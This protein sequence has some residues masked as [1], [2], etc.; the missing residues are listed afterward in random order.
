MFILDS[1]LGAPTQHSKGDN[2]RSLFLR[3]ATVQP[4]WPSWVGYI[5]LSFPL[6]GQCLNQLLTDEHLGKTQDT[7]TPVNRDLHPWLSQA[8][9]VRGLL[10]L[11]KGYLEQAVPAF[12]GTV[13]I[14]SRRQC[15]QMYILRD[16]RSCHYCQF[17]P[18]A[19][20]GPLVSCQSWERVCKTPMPVPCCLH[21]CAGRGPGGQSQCSGHSCFPTI[22]CTQLPN[23]VLSS[24]RVYGLLKVFNSTSS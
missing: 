4:G 3:L 12:L 5:L 17:L 23:T 6:G 22:G 7:A 9:V 24:Q 15:A 21:T 18:R 11:T 1:A 13:R 14:Y 20:P 2:G 10:I 8:Q 19:F 16:V